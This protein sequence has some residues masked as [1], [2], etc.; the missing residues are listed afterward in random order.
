MNKKE[1]KLWNEKELKLWKLAEETMSVLASPTIA[2]GASATHGSV[3]QDSS[4]SAFASGYSFNYT[5]SGG[6]A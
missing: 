1:L 3:C 4:A 5:K 6:N 2:V